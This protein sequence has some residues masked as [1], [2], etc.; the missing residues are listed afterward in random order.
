MRGRA[1]DEHRVRPSELHKAVISAAEESARYPRLKALMG[2]I[3]IETQDLASRS[4]D[5]VCAVPA[6]YYN[7][8]AEQG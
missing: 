8:G 1:L 4:V 5:R 7:A 6:D 2:W 3:L